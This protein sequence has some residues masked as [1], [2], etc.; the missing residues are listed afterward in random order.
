SAARRPGHRPCMRAP[1]CLKCRYFSVS[2][3]SRYPRSCAVFGIKSKRL[4][5]LE[6]FRATGRHCPAFEKSPKIKEDTRRS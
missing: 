3:D 6:V 2:W 5:S 4:P 1:N